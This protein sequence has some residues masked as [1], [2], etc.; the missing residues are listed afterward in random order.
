MKVGWDLRI[1]LNRH[2]TAWK[3]LD[4]PSLGD[5]S[6]GMVPHCNDPDFRPK[7]THNLCILIHTTLL[8]SFLNWFLLNSNKHLQTFS[9]V[10]I[11]KNLFNFFKQNQFE[12]HIY[13][14]HLEPF[15]L[16]LGTL[17]IHILFQTCKQFIFQYTKSFQIQN[18]F[19]KIF[20]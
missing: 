1:G 6:M 15:V 8:F 13:W 14:S 17:P 5:F 20:V 18:H 9:N 4:D 12:H 19:F 11:S 10:I 7:K 2:L 16:N 3:C